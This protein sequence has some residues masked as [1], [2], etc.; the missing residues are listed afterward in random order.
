MIAHIITSSVLI[1]GIIVLRAIFGKQMSQRGKYA[2]WLFVAIKLLIPLPMYESN[3]SIMNVVKFV[4]SQMTTE[5]AA[6][7]IK[8]KSM[9]DW[10]QNYQ[11][12]D[13]H[14]GNTQKSNIES[15]NHQNKNAQDVD[16]KQLNNTVQTAIQP[17]GEKI[18]GVK[19]SIELEDICFGIWIVGVF[20]CSGC[21]ICSNIRFYNQLRKHRKCIT[22]YS[23]KLRLYE[24]DCVN[25]PC[26]F[27]VVKPAI[28]LTTNLA[29]EEEKVNHIITHELI[30]YKHKDYIW[31]YVR[32]L[33][34]V[35]YWYH[36]L[37]WVAAFLSIRDSELAC[38]EG[39][40]KCLGDENRKAYGIT[41]IEMASGYSAISNLIVCSTSIIGGKKEMKKRMEMIVRKPKM[42]I[43][44]FIMFLFLLV[45]VTGCTFGK[46][47]NDTKKE[48]IATE[49][50]VQQEKNDT[51]TTE[52][53]PQLQSETEQPN[54]TAD[55]LADIEGKLVSK[56]VEGKVCIQV[57]PSDLVFKNRTL[58]GFYYV[59]DEEM[60][61]KL[62]KLIQKPDKKKEMVSYWWKNYDYKELGYSLY[63]ND[64]ILDVNSN[65][66]LINR[67]E[68]TFEINKKLCNLLED[69]LREELGYEPVDVKNI[70]NIV[71][72]KID[73][74]DRKDEKM[75]SQTI[76]DKKI[77][78]IFEEWFANGEN[79]H[80]GSACPFEDALLTLT[81]KNGEVIK[82]SM[83][84]DSCEVF[85]VNGAYYEYK[86][87]KYSKKRPIKD[88]YLEY[89]DNI[90]GS[91]EH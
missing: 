41:L 36:P 34:V 46:A 54:P 22:G 56:P 30:H 27:G 3:I 83:A 6:K 4:E 10:N 21:F 67:E 73:Y 85:M 60:Q 88:S 65:C 44:T 87:G 66:I 45:G 64:M 14:N 16:K 26:L 69:I 76:E 82:L 35:I 62:C 80:G 5:E 15:S 9:L 20:V 90:P 63:Y 86:P 58:G 53:T 47:K 32:C 12:S 18:S 25:S 13:S 28:Y 33:C 23:C 72:A 2:L 89:F 42:L 17:A 8:N 74:R 29:L 52:E 81:L 1:I 70:K 77:L 59:P 84:T 79:I 43:S 78:K 50:N 40:I 91:K 48:T 31:T 39:V 51:K 68:E 61:K 19:F 75:Y 55:V 7:L 57:Y 38:D 37:V 11:I 71:S 24:T 49:R